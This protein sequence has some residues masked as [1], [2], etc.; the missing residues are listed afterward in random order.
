MRCGCHVYVDSCGR[1]WWVTNCLGCEGLATMVMGAEMIDKYY[2]G[3]S[4]TIQTSLKR[5]SSGKDP[6]IINLGE[7]TYK[8]EDR[9]FELWIANKCGLLTQ[10]NN[11]AEKQFEAERKLKQKDSFQKI[12]RTPKL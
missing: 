2:L 3:T 6:L 1:G 8:L 10:K 5:F 4:S 7:N 12:I 11:D 9:F